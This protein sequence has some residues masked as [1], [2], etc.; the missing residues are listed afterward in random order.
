MEQVFAR[1]CWL[2]NKNKMPFIDGKYVLDAKTQKKWFSGPKVVN[3]S[4]VKA[5]GACLSEYEEQVLFV[6]WLRLHEY[7]FSAIPN[8]T[9]TTSYSQKNKNTAQGVCAGLP[10]LLVLVKKKLV[11]I[12]M[13]KSDRKPKNGGCGGVSEVQREWIDALNECDNCQAYVCYSYE[14]AVAVI[15]SLACLPK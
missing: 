10:D 12:E 13:K 5:V 9:Y 15:E 7:K 14:E 4:K 2:Y 6:K 11:W 3:K 8:S 1:R